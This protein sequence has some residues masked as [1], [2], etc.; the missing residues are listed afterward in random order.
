MNRNKKP[1]KAQLREA[2]R[3]RFSEPIGF[4]IIHPDGTYELAPGV[5]PEQARII[6]RRRLATQRF[7]RT[8]DRKYL[9]DEGLAPKSD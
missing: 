2:A 7:L 8:G 9:E 1:T 6:N 4:A 3:A 5:T